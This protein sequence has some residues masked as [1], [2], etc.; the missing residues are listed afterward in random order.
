MKQ[1]RLEAQLSL[2]NSAGHKLPT[3]Y[4]SR[5]AWIHFTV[6][7]RDNRVIFESGKLNP[8]GSISGNDNDAS[9]DLYEPHY[10]RIERSDQVQIYEGILAGPDDKVTTVLLTAVRY[11][12]DNRLLPDGFEKAAAEADISVKGRG[13]GRR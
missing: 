2:E 3:A 8:D 4:P 1:G 7:G 11:I 9:A 6:R 5:R 12:K 10:D 13:A